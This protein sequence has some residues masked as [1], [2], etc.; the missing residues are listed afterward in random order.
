M[1]GRM[2]KMFEDIGKKSGPDEVVTIDNVVALQ[3]PFDEQQPRAN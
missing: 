1:P 2:G 3:R